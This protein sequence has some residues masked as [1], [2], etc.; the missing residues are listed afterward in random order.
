MNL[1]ISPAELRTRRE[2]GEEIV[3]LDCRTEV[4]RKIAQIDNSIHAPLAELQAML[5]ELLEYAE[6]TVVVHCHHGV[7]SLQATTYLRAEGFTKAFSLAGGIDRWS[8]EID[9][10]IPRY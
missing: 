5:P 7:R 8:L 9:T 3:V 4:E 10:S 1:E 6:T 2:E